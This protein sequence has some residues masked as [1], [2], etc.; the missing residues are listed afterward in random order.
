MSQF[1]ALVELNY[2][3]DYVVEDLNYIILIQRVIDYVTEE[4]DY[5]ISSSLIFKQNGL[6]GL[7]QE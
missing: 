3:I 5:L 6:S 1:R 4:L 2:V 7:I